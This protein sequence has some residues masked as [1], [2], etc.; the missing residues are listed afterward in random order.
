MDGDEQVRVR[1]LPD[2][3]VTAEDGGKILDR[4]PK[5]MAEWRCRGWG[6]RPIK[7]GGR[8]FYDYDECLAMARGE[9]PVKPAV[10]A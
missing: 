10:A 3:R 6:P 5:T 1:I 9:K 7:V 2:R 4:T 8:I